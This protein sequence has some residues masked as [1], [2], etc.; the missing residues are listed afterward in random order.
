MDI[1]GLL[2]AL[3]VLCIVV[4]VAYWLITNLLP[5]PM[6]KF[7]IAIMLVLV[8]IILIGYLTGGVNFGIRGI[9]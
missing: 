1:T 8:V 5:E 3:L 9:R 7:A 6:R 2:I 4:A